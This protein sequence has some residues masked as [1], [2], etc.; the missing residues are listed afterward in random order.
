MEVPGALLENV[1][2]ALKF[3]AGLVVDDVTKTLAAMGGKTYVQIMAALTKGIGGS[4]VTLGN[5][6]LKLNGATMEIVTQAL[7]L[8][9]GLG[10]DGVAK[11]LVGLGV[12]T[13][14]GVMGFMARCG[15]SDTYTNLSRG[16]MS[17]SGCTTSIV[18]RALRIGA[19]LQWGT[20]AGTL[21]N[22]GVTKWNDIMYYLSHCGAGGKYSEMANGLLTLGGATKEIVTQALR[23]GAGLIWSD[24]AGT[25]VN[26]GVT[27]WNDIMYYLTHCGVSDTYATFSRALLTLGG[28]TS[29]ITQALRLG[30]GLT[31]DGVAGT[32]VNL[33]VTKFNDLMYY[34]SHCGAGGLLSEMG[35]ALMPLGASWGTVANALLNGAG[36][37]LQQVAGL[38]YY[39][40][41]R[42]LDDVLRAII[43]GI[44]GYYSD[45]LN[46][47]YY[48]IGGV[49]I[50]TLAAMLVRVTGTSAETVAAALW[51]MGAGLSKANIVWALIHG[52]GLSE[53]S[54]W[55]ILNPF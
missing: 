32:L 20:V 2:N 4:F 31:W 47:I 46:A 38:L 11:T 35:T 33:G 26:M 7:K 18:T 52:L 27:K 12:T 23:L 41:G 30:A 6:L 19:A 17:L 24:V 25:L 53:W 13:F 5:S 10:W 43:S 50:D 49:G 45:M 40:M 22:L 21:A 28:T 48:G 39:N 36:R 15:V 54:A 34:M 8:G 16:L 51:N 55:Q 29:I 3:V 42:G 9:G 44:G 37:T 1:A 14:D